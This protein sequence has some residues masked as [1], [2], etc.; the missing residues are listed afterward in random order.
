MHTQRELQRCLHGVNGYKDARY[1]YSRDVMGQRL[2]GRANVSGAYNPP[3]YSSRP[4]PIHLLLGQGAIAP[5]VNGS[6]HRNFSPPRP[7]AFRDQI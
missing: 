6:S 4:L 7:E 2:N 3:C 5:D 1:R